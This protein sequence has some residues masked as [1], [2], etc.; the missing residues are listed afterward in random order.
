MSFNAIRENKILAEIFGF[1]VF[2]QTGTLANRLDS[3]EMPRNV[4]SHQNLHFW[5]ISPIHVAAF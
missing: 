4:A 2:P 1:T 5:F 3:D